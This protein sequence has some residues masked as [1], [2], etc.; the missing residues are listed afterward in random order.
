M[1]GF[2]S[3]LIQRFPSPRRTTDAP[4]AN[5]LADGRTRTVGGRPFADRVEVLNADPYLMIADSP[6]QLI[7]VFDDLHYDRAD[8]DM[9]SGPMRR[10]AADK[11]APLGFKQIS[12]S[13]LENRA[14]DIRVLLPK[15]K[16]LGASPFDATRY[17][18]RREQDYFILSPTQAA[19]QIIDNY[20]PDDAARQLSELVVKH[21]V[22]L[23]RIFDFLE[24][25]AAHTAFKDA[26]G[27]LTYLQRQA[28]SGT[29]LK[30]RRA[31]R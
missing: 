3:A 28:V 14:E 23:L 7:S 12:G 2:L 5:D 19:C 8:L 4:S 29:S 9:V 18:P 17:T 15:F 13:V 31:L 6:L 11:L 1:T 25:K 27:Q 20:A 30:T 24:R 10:R 16:A 22:N 26:I 21:P